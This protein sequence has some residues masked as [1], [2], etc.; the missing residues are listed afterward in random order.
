MKGQSRNG[1][2]GKFVVYLLAVIAVIWLLEKVTAPFKSQPETTQSASTATPAKPVMA[3]HSTRVSVGETGVLGAQAANTYG[4][5]L[6]ATD[7]E[8]N[9]ALVKAAIANDDYGIRELIGEWRAIGVRAGTKLRVL[10][11]AGL[12]VR[13]V[14]ILEGPHTG[15]KVYA[16]YE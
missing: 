6:L 3:E 13:E 10:G 15:L 2:S 9:E 7:K 14:R 8:A 12:G 4:S 11:H 1:S 5:V 16:P